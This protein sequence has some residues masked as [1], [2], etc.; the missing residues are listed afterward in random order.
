MKKHIFIAIIAATTITA[1]AI[2]ALA[3]SDKISKAQA[4]QIALEN[5]GLTE[6]EVTFVRTHLDR[7]DG[8]MEYEIEFYCRNMEYDYDIDAVTGAIIS[9]DQDAEY[10]SPEIPGSGAGINAIIRYVM[11]IEEDDYDLDGF[12]IGD[13]DMDDFLDWIIW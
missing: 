5:A 3:Q 9:M 6:S 7:D 10:Y 12:D 4:K 2:P 8:R 13:F 1:S 11:D